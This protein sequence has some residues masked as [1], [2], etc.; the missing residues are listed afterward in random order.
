L[1]PDLIETL[2]TAPAER[3]NSAEKALVCTLNSLIESGDGWTTCADSDCAFCVPWLLSKP[4]RMK[5]FWVW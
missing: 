3:P 2:T 5:L 1:V 4:S